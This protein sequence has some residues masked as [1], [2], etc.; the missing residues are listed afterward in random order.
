MPLSSRTRRPEL[1]FRGEVD[2]RVMS[3]SRELVV[4][5]ANLPCFRFLALTQ[6]LFGATRVHTS[7]SSVPLVNGLPSGPRIADRELTSNDRQ[8][9]SPNIGKRICHGEGGGIGH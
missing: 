5:V 6:T 3:E 7:F 4:E 8:T 9:L 1:T 2:L